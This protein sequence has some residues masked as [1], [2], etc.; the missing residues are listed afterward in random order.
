M[1]I[2]LVGVS[3]TGWALAVWVAVTIGRVVS[4][5]VSA[6]PK[7]MANTHRIK[8]K[9]FFMFLEAKIAFQPCAV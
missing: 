2:S 5:D 1:S 4:H 6:N 8:E 7:L 3:V 9:V